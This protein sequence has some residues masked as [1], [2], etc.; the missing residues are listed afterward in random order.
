M[1]GELDKT[2]LNN[3]YEEAKFVIERYKYAFGGR[4][5][6]ELQAHTDEVQIYLNEQLV[7]L[8][9]ETNTPY[10]ITTDAHYLNKEDQK[11]HSLFIQIN[12]DRE[13]G[14]TYTDCYIQSEEE[15]YEKCSYLP[16]E[17]I[18]KALENT[19]KIAELCNVELPL[20]APIMPVEKVPTPY[21]TQIEYLWALC[22]QGWK[23]RGIDKKSS[24]KQKEYKD[25]LQYEMNAIEKMGFEGYYLFVWGYANSVKRRGI[26]RGSGGGSLV[27]YLIKIVDIDPI[28]HGLY[29][30]RFIDVSALPLLEQG[31]ITKKELKI[32]DFDLDF[33][34]EDREKVVI[35]NIVKD[36]ECFYRYIAFLLG[37]NYVLSALEVASGAEIVG[38]D[39]THRT[40]QIPALYEKMLQ[41]A[42]TAPERFKEI[43]YLIKAISEDGVIPEQFEALYNVFKKVVK[44]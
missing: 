21:K 41:T 5:F 27:A 43:D 42:A 1:A 29:F 20:S 28:R 44:L 35:S 11:Y 31:K 3:G 8:A 6:V 13:V 2:I 14:E 25:R 16:K 7:K 24:E 39:H 38:G 10:I 12:Q 19:N 22:K 26:A 34:P 9:E 33:G 23:D 37:D 36:K 30:E 17:K 40:I 4:Y 15:I 18:E 32:P